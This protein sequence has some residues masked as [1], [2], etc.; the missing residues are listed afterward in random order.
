M[1]CACDTCIIDTCARYSFIL[2][3]PVCVYVCVCV[4]VCVCVC[5]PARFQQ[6]ELAQYFSL[7]SHRTT[8]EILQITLIRIIT[9]GIVILLLVGMGAAIIEAT[10]YSWKQV[11]VCQFW[12]G[13]C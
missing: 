9:N 5:V 13:V 3:V 2:F 8:R 11:C 7:S 10:I 6:E 12:H 4:F 1:A